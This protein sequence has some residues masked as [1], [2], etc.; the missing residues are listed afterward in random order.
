MSSSDGQE[1]PCLPNLQTKLD[2]PTTPICRNVKGLLNVR[3]TWLAFGVT[4]DPVAVASSIFEEVCAGRFP[5]H[6]GGEGSDANGSL[7]AQVYFGRLYRTATAQLRRTE[8]EEG[9]LRIEVVRTVH[10]VEHRRSAITAAIAA[11]LS[12]VAPP[13]EEAGLPEAGVDAATAGAVALLERELAWMEKMHVSALDL[14]N[15][16]RTIT[17]LGEGPT[18]QSLDP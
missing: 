7:P 8:E 15:S 1:I 3:D 10:W 5:W 2:Y 4:P 17:P 11:L 12:G 9:Y 6:G 16:V 18:L 14:L 13:D